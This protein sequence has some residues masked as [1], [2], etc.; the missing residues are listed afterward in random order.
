MKEN[1][2]KEKYSSNLYNK[3]SDTFTFYF[4]PMG[5]EPN[6]TVRPFL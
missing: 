1:K 2:I 4:D 3:P 5:L 6:F